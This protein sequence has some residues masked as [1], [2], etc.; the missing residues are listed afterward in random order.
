MQRFVHIIHA[1]PFDDRKNW[2]YENLYKEKPPSTEINLTPENN[3][4][5]VER[6]E[7]MGLRIVSECVLTLSVLDY[8]YNNSSILCYSNCGAV[9]CVYYNRFDLETK[10]VLCVFGTRCSSVCLI[11]NLE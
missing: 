6:G 5:Q 1:Q 11:K 7:C 3:L 10:A 4:I 8:A 2:F 9:E